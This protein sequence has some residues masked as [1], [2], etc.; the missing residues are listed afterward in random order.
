MKREGTSKSLL[1]CVCLKKSRK[2]IHLECQ[3]SEEKKIECLQ[4]V[5]VLGLTVDPATPLSTM[6]RNRQTGA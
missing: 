4:T 5:T 6:H 1:V 3:T 2:K